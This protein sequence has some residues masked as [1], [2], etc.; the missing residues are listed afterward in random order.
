MIGKCVKDG[1]TAVG[2]VKTK[3]KAGTG[4]GGCLPLI[5]NIFKGEMKKAGLS[6]STDLCAHFKMSRMDLYSIV[7][8]K[9]LTNFKE[10]METAGVKKTAVGC[11]V[12]KPAVG[13]ILATLY[14]AHVMEPS[15]HANQDTN[16]RFM[17][18][19][20][21]NGTFSVVPRVTGGEIQPDHLIVLGQVAK[22]YK[23]YSKVRACDAVITSTSAHSNCTD[24]RW[25]ADRSFRSSEARPSSNMEKAQRR[26]Y[27]IR[28]SVRQITSYGQVL[29]R[30][31]MVSVWHWRLCRPGH[32]ARKPIQGAAFST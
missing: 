15:H 32:T 20:Q 3:T 25:T 5:T 30:V 14:N 13:S 27:G 23:L 16:D 4:C 26:R 24:H 2:D 7:K 22:E 18:N 1:I 10:V 21:R 12:C 9:R 6:V 17:A 28:I 11:E 31:H 19:I 29:C 8:V